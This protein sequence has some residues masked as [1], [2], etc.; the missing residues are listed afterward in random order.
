MK[1]R[2]SFRQVGHPTDPAVDTVSWASLIHRE[3]CWHQHAQPAGKT[4]PSGSVHQL[5]RLPAVRSG[6]TVGLNSRRQRDAC[7]LLFGDTAF[8]S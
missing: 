7:Y 3:R 8:D 6:E 1:E 5:G 2:H 4:L